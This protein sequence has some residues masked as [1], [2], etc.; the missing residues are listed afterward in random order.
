MRALGVV[1]SN[2]ENKDFS[3]E[4]FVQ[5]FLLTHPDYLPLGTQHDS[6]EFMQELFNILSQS[7]GDMSQT[8][9]KLFEI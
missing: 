7:T 2:L 3:P 4:M 6:D 9:K 1:F 8:I 5:S